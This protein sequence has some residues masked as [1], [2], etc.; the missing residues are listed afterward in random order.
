[1]PQRLLRASYTAPPPAASAFADF[2]FRGW[3]ALSE[4]YDDVWGPVTAAFAP[5]LLAAAGVRR[6]SLV[7]DLACGPGYA[8]RAAHAAGA[9]VTGLD[10]S[11]RMIRLARA[12]S[13]DV[14][15]FATGDAHSLPFAH[16]SF[17]AVICNFGAQHFA[18]PGRALAEMARVLKPGGFCA[19]TVWAEN[20]LNCA[21]DVLERA[22]ESFASADTEVPRGPDYHHLT[23]PDGRTRLLRRAGFERMS[24]R[25]SLCAVTWRMRS[26]HDLFEAELRGSVR[27]GARLRE[28]GEFRLSC[29]KAAMEADIRGRFASDDGFSLPL[30]AY[31]ACAQA[32]GA[33]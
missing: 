2:E 19:F 24:I 10:F 6:G 30:A 32:P 27:S 20:C 18:D 15:A 1:M 11:P 7:L 26:P 31:V 3:E 14:I 13:P 28:Q 5:G 12:T 25:S 4:A 21:G 29:I 17:D 22:V 8:A 33:S 23:N 16:A 9:V